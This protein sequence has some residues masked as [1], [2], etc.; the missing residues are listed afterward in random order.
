MLPI[1]NDAVGN[2]FAIDGRVIWRRDA[3]TFEWRAIHELPEATYVGVAVSGTILVCVVRDKKGLRDETVLGVAAY[4]PVLAPPPSDDGAR[5]VAQAAQ[6]YA[7][8][9][10]AQA[11]A[12]ADDL[13]RLAQTVEALP[14]TEDVQTQAQARAA[15]AVRAIFEEAKQHHNEVRTLIADLM[16]K[17][18][19]AA[20]RNAAST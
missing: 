6:A 12:L 4:T 17:E 18:A 11:A 13:A 10:A 2:I 5:A 1:T 20:A 8:G 16:D 7:E 19:R 3:A 15:D 9:V 14:T